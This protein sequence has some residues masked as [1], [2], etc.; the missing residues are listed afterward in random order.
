[1]VTDRCPPDGLTGRVTTTPTSH[2]QL[3]QPDLDA[4]AHDAEARAADVAWLA[5]QVWRH[6]LTRARRLQAVEV[7]AHRAGTGHRA[8]GSQP[9][10]HPGQSATPSTG[11]SA[12]SST[13]QSAIPSMTSSTS[14]CLR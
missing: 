10:R 12:T 7:P 6:V 9:L 8:P 13:G 14:Q 1:M 5:L 11:Q 2:G 4:A 3:E